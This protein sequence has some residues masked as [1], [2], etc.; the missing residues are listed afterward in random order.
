MACRISELFWRQSDAN[1][2][3]KRSRKEA[4][5]RFGSCVNQVIYHRTIRKFGV[6]CEPRGNKPNL[7]AW[8]YLHVFHD[9]DLFH[10]RT[11]ENFRRLYRI[12]TTEFPKMLTVSKE[13]SS[14]CNVKPIAV[15]D[16]QLNLKSSLA[17][18]IRTNRHM[19]ERLIFCFLKV[20]YYWLRWRYF[21]QHL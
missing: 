11:I 2:L 7:P 9:G 8:R 3:H 17:C 16:N 5:T 15:F 10:F 14:T 4:L 13:E 19:A 20:L 12:G 6:S 18:Q 21:P 1:E